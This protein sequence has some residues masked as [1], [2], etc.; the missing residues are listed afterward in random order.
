MA[1]QL[2][3]RRRAHGQSVNTNAVPKN[4]AGVADVNAAYTRNP[5]LITIEFDSAT[6]AQIRGILQYAKAI[7]L[8]LTTTTI[9]TAIT[10]VIPA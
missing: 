8:G 2:I 4:A 1:H 6:E 3:I 10:A 5:D 7:D 9:E